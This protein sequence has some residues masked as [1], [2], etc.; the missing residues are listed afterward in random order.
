MRSFDFCKL[1][2]FSLRT[3]FI[4]MRNQ[5][6]KLV[7]LVNSYVVQ[8]EDINVRGSISSW[9]QVMKPVFI[10]DTFLMWIHVLKWISKTVSFWSIY[11]QVNLAQNVWRCVTTWDDLNL[12][13]NFTLQPCHVNMKSLSHQ[14]IFY[15]TKFI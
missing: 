7:I 4:I 10:S 1:F 5:D 14:K 3:F 15:E 12:C 8:Y 13:W 9:H 2:Y 6:L 11:I